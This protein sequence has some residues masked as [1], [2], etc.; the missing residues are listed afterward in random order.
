[1]TIPVIFRHPRLTTSPSLKPC[2]ESCRLEKQETIPASM[3]NEPLR[4]AS[5]DGRV[6]GILIRIYADRLTWERPYKRTC[7]MPSPRPIGSAHQYEPAV[8]A[9][10]CPR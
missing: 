9:R 4:I 1:M 7:P 6:T 5:G 10:Y 3:V 8:P 2:Y